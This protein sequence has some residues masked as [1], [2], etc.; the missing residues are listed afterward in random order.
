M[1]S[2]LTSIALVAALSLGSVACGKDKGGKG[3]E[4][5]TAG[6]PTTA[7]PM[8][9]VAGS[10]GQQYGV[11]DQPSSGKAATNRPQMSAS[12]KQSYTAGMAAF[13]SGDLVGAKTQFQA[14]IKA[15]SKAYQAHYSLAVVRERL[16]DNSGALSSY[17]RAVEIVP[18][19]EPA[20]LGYALL[21]A[22]T[23][24]LGEADEYLRSKESKFP[25]SAAITAGR[26]EIKSLDKEHTEAQRLAQRAL[27]KNPD[28]RPA[29]VTIARDHYRNRRLDLALYTLQAILDG[30]GK[31]NPARDPNNAEA[32]LLRGLILREEGRHSAAIKEFEAVV[33]TRPD[34]VEARVQLA[35]YVLEAGNA[36]KAAQLL[37]GALRYDKRNLL[38]HLNLGD[39]YRLLGRTADAKKKLDYVKTKEPQ[40]PEVHYNLGLMYL[41]S[42]SVPGVSAKAAAQRAIDAFEEYK[43]LRPRPKP[44]E[45]DDTDSLITRAKT[46]KA[47]IESEEAEKKKS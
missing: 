30:H 27:K 36:Q 2:N 29:M 38:A 45:P 4:S 18:D 37:E 16:Q 17:R 11:T 40:M 39:A 43:R 8:A 6:Q 47:I 21:L 14:A 34:I 13:K 5:P 33:A 41:F 20:I 22:R 15:D 35:T 24:R 1:K 26:A 3:A 10:G 31:E 46:R 23:G 7:G 12:A 28:Y 9:P 32:H 25:K 19:Y 42:Q 44:G